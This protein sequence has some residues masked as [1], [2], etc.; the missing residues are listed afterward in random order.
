ME[1]AFSW[2]GDLARWMAMWVP[3]LGV[4]RATHGGVKFVRGK[5]VKAI[6]PGLFLWW[7]LV[8][9]Y[10]IIPT[11]RHPV[12]LPSQSLTTKDGKSIM[13]SVTLVV[14]ISDVIR[15]LGRTWDVDDM[16]SDVGTAASI[17][18]VCG[19]TW[20][21]LRKGLEEDVC[22]ELVQ[23]A[24]KLLRPYGVKVIK[25]RF[26]DI[27]EHMVIRHEGSSGG[28]GIIPVEE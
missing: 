12:D 17:P 2:L 20:S 21:E 1:A 16:I 5:K 22:D 8:T 26:T 4:C 27:A 13:V 19:R 15:A 9:E 7:P 10:V 18:V 11:V 6:R 14:E 23:E 28:L 25:G 3:R 24:R